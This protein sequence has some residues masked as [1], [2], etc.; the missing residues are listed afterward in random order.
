[1][2]LIQGSLKW[3][4][5][6]SNLKNILYN[7]RSLPSHVNCE[8]IQERNFKEDI[9]LYVFCRICLL[10]LSSI[11]NKNAYLPPRDSIDLPLHICIYVYHRMFMKFSIYFQIAQHKDY[12]F[13][14]VSVCVCI[15]HCSVITICQYVYLTVHFHELTLI[16]GTYLV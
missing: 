16:E 3:C 10:I 2:Y 6:T 4:A 11:L 1:M 5:H 13:V 12:F 14:F 15:H 9:Y 8:I 7:K